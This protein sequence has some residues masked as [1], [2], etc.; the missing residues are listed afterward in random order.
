M[1][2]GSRLN[3]GLVLCTDSFSLNDVIRLGNVLMLKFDL[4]VTIQGW[5]QGKPRIY[6]K[7]RKY[8]NFNTIS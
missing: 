7:K 4:H 8:A 1:G 2:D 6:I 5:Q 3:D